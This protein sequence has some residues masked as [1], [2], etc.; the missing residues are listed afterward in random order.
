MDAQV[1]QALLEAGEETTKVAISQALN[2]AKAYAASTESS[3]DD[4][5]VAAVQLLHD[6]FLADLVDEINPND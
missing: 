2:V 1:K 5:V 6:T 3:I 4:S